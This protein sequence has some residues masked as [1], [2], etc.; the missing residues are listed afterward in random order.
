MNQNEIINMM[1]TVGAF[2]LASR[3]DVSPLVV[4]E[5]ASS[6][7]PLVLSDAIG[8]RQ[9]FLI[10]GYNGYSFKS[11]DHIDLAYKMLKISST[12]P[13]KLFELGVNSHKLSR[14]HNA[15]FVA[16]SL[17]SIFEKI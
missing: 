16:A 11:E 6:G 12:S 4:H 15:E 14:I 1:Q 2:T 5:F 10:D 8:N 3:T 9:I 17:M 7:L 13:Q